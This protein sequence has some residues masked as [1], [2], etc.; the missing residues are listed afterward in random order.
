MNR[1]RSL[2][3]LVLIDEKALLPHGLLPWPG[4]ELCDGNDLL[5]GLIIACF[6]VMVSTDES[7]L[8]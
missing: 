1:F 7:L 5:S 4:L 8:G 6:G 3:A 2:H